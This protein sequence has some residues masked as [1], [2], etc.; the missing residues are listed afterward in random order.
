VKLIKEWE[1]QKILAIDDAIDYS[2]S[3]SSYFA[4][5]AFNGSS[6]KVSTYINGGQARSLIT[7]AAAL[8]NGCGGINLP[9][10]VHLGGGGDLGQPPAREV[11]VRGFGFTNTAVSSADD[12]A[13]Y[14]NT[15]TFWGSSLLPLRITRRRQPP[16]RLCRKR[17]VGP[18]CQRA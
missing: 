13:A 12:T 2:S 7:P 10:S 3:G 15:T 9:G 16:S 6:N 1:D 5:D 18:S 17:P 11:L 14:G 4:M 8:C